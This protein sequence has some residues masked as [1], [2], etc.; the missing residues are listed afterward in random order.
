MV[1]LLRREPG[2]RFVVPAADAQLKAS[3]QGLQRA[4][5]DLAT[6]MT[7]IDG[8][9][10]DCLEAADVV[11]VASG[12]ATLETALYKRPMVIAYRM[13]ALSAWLMRRKGRIP[14]VGLPNILSGE[15]VVPEFLQEQAT[16]QA[17]ASALQSQLHDP[18]CVPGLNSAL[19]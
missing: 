18:D 15:F 2:L 19:P 10:H 8:R 13:P 3:L 11:L 6:A 17:L 14:Y 5:P 7:I 1:E 4:H 12:T 16:P 9:S